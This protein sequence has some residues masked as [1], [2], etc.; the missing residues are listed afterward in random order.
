[1]DVKIIVLLR[2]F[3]VFFP[4]YI[5]KHEMFLHVGYI[6]SRVEEVTSS[7]SAY[8]KALDVGFICHNDGESARCDM[9]SWIRHSLPSAC[10][11]QLK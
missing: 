8:L 11:S 10:W 9:Y 3:N 4:F 5:F 2:S 1:M 7:P 6:S